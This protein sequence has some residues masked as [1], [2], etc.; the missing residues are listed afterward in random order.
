V[1]GNPKL[2]GRHRRPPSILAI[3]D[4]QRSSERVTKSL[5]YQ[6]GTSGSRPELTCRQA[7]RSIS[8]QKPLSTPRKSPKM[9]PS[10]GHGPVWKCL[11]SVFC[12]NSTVEDRGRASFCNAGEKQ[13][14]SLPLDAVFTV[15]IR[16][17][18]LHR[19]HPPYHLCQFL[20]MTLF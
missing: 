8:V 6:Q 18:P 12:E 10:Y 20:C 19:F 17:T 4:L 2:K 13:S 14:G 3:F 7:A 1:G 5:G 15:K 9:T 16:D 11:T